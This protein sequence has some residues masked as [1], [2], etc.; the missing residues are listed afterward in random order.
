MAQHS[1]SA[2]R[3]LFEQQWIT[4]LELNGQHWNVRQIALARSSFYAGALTV[5]QTIMNDVSPQAEHEQ[6]LLDLGA[7]L[8][9]F[10]VQAKG[11]MQ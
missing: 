6:N 4:F 1:T 5:F 8:Q 2:Q 10:V 9:E 11:K 7:E 3:K